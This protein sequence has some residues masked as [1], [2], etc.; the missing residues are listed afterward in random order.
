MKRA[1]FFV[2]FVAAASLLGVAGIAVASEAFDG[3]K[4]A[5]A[6][7]H[8]LD[9]AIEAGYSFR[10]PQV[11]GKTCVTEP[12]E[13]AMGVHMVNLGL[14][15]DPSIDADEPEV[16]VYEPRND[17]TL[18]LVAVE[19]VV[20]QADSARPSLFGKQLTSWA[21][22][23]ATAFRRSTRCTRGSGSRTRAG[24]STLGTRTWSA[25]AP[26]RRATGPVVP[27]APSDRPASD[28]VKDVPVLCG[29][30]RGLTILLDLVETFELE[31]FE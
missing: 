18:K 31:A 14:V 4:P 15:V 27:P 10:L 9:K 17:G 28:D 29:A 25:T 21:R 6:R 24:S 26:E 30:G 11:S 5:T 16:L 8:D 20:F 2:A 22:R 3:A 1:R 13:G 23:T 7:F 12:G 19:Y